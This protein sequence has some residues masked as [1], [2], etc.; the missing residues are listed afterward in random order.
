[1]T[2]DILEGI[3]ASPRPDP[4]AQREEAE[5]LD[6]L[7]STLCRRLALH[8]PCTNADAGRPPSRATAEPCFHRNHRRDILHA[9]FLCTIVGGTGAL[10]VEGDYHQPTAYHSATRGELRSLA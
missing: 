1:M 5:Q 10:S 7:V 9:E 8:H 2:S 4:V 3:A 6:R